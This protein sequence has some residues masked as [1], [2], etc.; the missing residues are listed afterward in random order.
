MKSKEK[1]FGFGKFEWK[2]MDGIH[3]FTKEW[4]VVQM[5]LVFLGGIF[6]SLMSFGV[7]H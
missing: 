2:K 1:N 7:F 5:G 4:F 3:F 6:F